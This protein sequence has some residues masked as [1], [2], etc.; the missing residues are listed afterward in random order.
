M[1]FPESLQEDKIIIL[2]YFKK[3]IQ[4]FRKFQKIVF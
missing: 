1:K 3:G 4:I 2:E